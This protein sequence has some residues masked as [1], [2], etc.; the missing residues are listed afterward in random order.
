MLGA[1]D[2]AM[3]FEL[4][5]HI[6]AVEKNKTLC[7]LKPFLCKS[8]K[9]RARAQHLKTS[10]VNQKNHRGYLPQIF[11]ENSNAL[12]TMLPTNQEEKKV[13]HHVQERYAN[14]QVN[15]KNSF[16]RSTQFIL[17]KFSPIQPS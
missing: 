13:I 2:S 17:K 11:K 7:Y 5:H 16:I 12:V 15:I 8:Q 9:L 6:L 4:L 14:V 1:H 10:C 3:T